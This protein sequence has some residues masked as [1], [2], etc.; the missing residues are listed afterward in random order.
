MSLVKNPVFISLTAVGNAVVLFGTLSLYFVESD[1]NPSIKSL[2]DTLWWSVTTITTVGY[3]DVSPVTA[4]GKVIGIFMMIVGTALF[5]SFTALFAEALI[6]EDIVDL[7]TEI[8]K[9]TRKIRKV[10]ESG[11]IEASQQAR[12]VSLLE[13]LERSYARER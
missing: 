4:L 11:G 10:A 1:I 12:I 6:S 13:E 8:Q 7:D 5:C 3:G 9:L 2:L